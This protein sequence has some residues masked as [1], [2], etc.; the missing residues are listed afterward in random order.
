MIK[1]TIFIFSLFLLPLLLGT[2]ALSSF[3]THE[4]RMRVERSIEDAC[5][6][7]D[8]LSRVLAGRMQDRFDEVHRNIFGLSAIL[9]D[10]DYQISEAEI[11]D[12]VK[13][14]VNSTVFSLTPELVKQRVEQL[15]WVD[16]AE[17][18]LAVYPTRLRVEVV[19][20]TP[21][22]V[23]E[24]DSESWLVSSSRKLIEPIGELRDPDL[25]VE[26][27]KLPR[28]EGLST[29]KGLE[30][31]TFLT[32]SNARFDYVLDGIYLLEMA[33]TLPFSVELYSVLSDGSLRL[34]PKGEYPDLLM[35]IA[36][37]EDAE[38]LG[39]RLNEVLADLA[40]RGEEANEIDLRFSNQV[41]VR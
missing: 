22:L 28:I 40:K 7:L 5:L 36:S 27:S 13:G 11:R 16:R 19:E 25:V 14:V 31:D 8:S 1:K 33:E 4:M 10:G 3:A 12:S 6:Y 32:S 20:S 38:Q 24:L 37:L 21:W 41:I 9:I 26:L 39:N 34:R 15:A 17:V 2:W 35:K 30:P 23:A 18:Q 29:I